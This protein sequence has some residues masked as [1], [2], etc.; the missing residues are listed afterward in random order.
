[1][2]L[3]YPRNI[4]QTTENFN[5]CNSIDSNDDFGNVLYADI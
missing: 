3:I 5:S 1:M 2:N 4:P